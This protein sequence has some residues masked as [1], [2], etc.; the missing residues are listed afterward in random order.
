[1][2]WLFGAVYVIGI[3]IGSL[4]LLSAFIIYC[5]SKSS[6]SVPNSMVYSGVLMIFLSIISSIKVGDFEFYTIGIIKTQG[7]NQERINEIEI[8]LSKLSKL[9]EHSATTQKN[10]ST[11][12]S[13]G[14]NSLTQNRIERIASKNMEKGKVRILYKRVDSPVNE[15]R[16]AFLDAGFNAITVPTNYKELSII[17]F[18]KSKNTAYIKYI[19]SHEHQ[20]EEVMS[21]I[22][23]LTSYKII[24]NKTYSKVNKGEGD[25]EVWLF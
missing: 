10:H 3:I 4:F 8:E 19:T 9:L 21:I 12:P 18:F 25:I 1:M 20:A 17:R 22:K 11:Q 24:D 15:L 7:N 13:T 16:K 14:K 5:K 6:D 2:D 23:E